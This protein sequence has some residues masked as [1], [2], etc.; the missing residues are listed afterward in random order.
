[1]ATNN[2]INN[3]LTNCT[4]LPL[5]TGVTGNL[6]VTH[7]NSGTSASS[8][9]FW[10]GDGTWATPSSSGLT[11]TGFQ[12]FTTAAS[13]TYTPTAG[14]VAILVE[15]T[16]GGGGGGAV[17][18]AASSVAAAGGGGSGSYQR[19]F[20]SSIGS[21]YS[22]TV[23]AGG[24]GGTAGANNGSSG[25]DSI[26][27]VMD[28]GGGAGGSGIAAVAITGAAF[29]Q[30][31]VGGNNPGTADIY[32]FG[33]PGSNG[34]MTLTAYAGGYGA[35]SYWGGGGR[36]LVQTAGTGG[37]TNCYGAGGGGATAA[38]GGSNAAGGRGGPGIVIVWEFS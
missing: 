33:G 30:G 27:D 22:Y 28:A 19:K 3:L 2:G 1:M 16:A 37:L 23:G 6:A 32:G 35:N 5:A 18:A 21:S 7:L 4:G 38:Q 13:G 15:I 10:R 26:F 34:A 11:L 31:G 17:A 9:T 24:A 14:T 12:I 8:T 36:G 20:Y 25:G 29:A